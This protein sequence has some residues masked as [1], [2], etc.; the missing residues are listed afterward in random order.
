MHIVTD[1]DGCLKIKQ[2]EHFRDSKVYSELSQSMGAAIAGA[3]ANK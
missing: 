1:D 2:L 3:Q